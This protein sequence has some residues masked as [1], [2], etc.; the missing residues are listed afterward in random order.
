MKKEHLI[1]ADEFCIHHH[2]EISFISSLHEFGLIEITQ[3]DQTVFIPVDQLP[4]LEKIVRLYDELNI[5]MEGID[6][7]THLLD[8]IED[9][10]NKMNE[11]RNKLRLY[12]DFE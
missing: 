4:K 5:N 12:E 6:A 7:I 2:I 9:L 10:Q 11:F 8:Q 3:I 1:A